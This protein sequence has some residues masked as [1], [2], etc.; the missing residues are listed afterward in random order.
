MPHH[1][2]RSSIA[3]H[4]FAQVK[5][6]KVRPLRQAASNRHGSVVF[7]C[8]ARKV[9]ILQALTE[10]EC[11]C[12][13][14]HPRGPHPLGP[15]M[16]CLQREAYWRVDL[17]RLARV[18]ESA[19]QQ[20]GA[21]LLEPRHVQGHVTQMQALGQHL[22]NDCGSVRPDVVVRQV[23]MRDGRTS[24]EQLRQ[25]RHLLRPDSALAQSQRGQR[26]AARQSFRQSFHPLPILSH[27]VS[28][29]VKMR[30]SR[31][32]TYSFRKLLDTHVSDSVSHQQQCRN[33]RAPAEQH[34]NPACAAFSEVVVA[35]IEMLERA[36]SFDAWG[37]PADCIWSQPI[38]TQVQMLE[39]VEVAHREEESKAHSPR[40][41]DLVPSQIQGREL[42]AVA[43]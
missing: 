4:V 31:S 19:G 24:L 25:N 13:R 14:L 36:A 42:L 39:L 20:E 7:Y 29:E 9:Q 26:G 21:I 27:P 18:C 30:Q 11:R 10:R 22:A 1:R 33:T 2:P 12:H 6:P 8:V 15:Q 35:E 38:A 17:W 3:D 32:S 34:P 28:G 5:P 16:D 41:S 23:K 40:V 43:E 37:Q